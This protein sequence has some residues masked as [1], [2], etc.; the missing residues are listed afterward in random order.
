MGYRQVKNE[1]K[2]VRE[3]EQKA[4]IKRK[5]LLCRNLESFRTVVG[6]RVAEEE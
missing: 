4:M 3:G 1:G 5:V 2:K 6:K